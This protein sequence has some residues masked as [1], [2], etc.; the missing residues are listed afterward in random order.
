M[1]GLS[2]VLVLVSLT[3]AALGLVVVRGI[4]LTTL[5]LLA[6]GASIALQAI[7]LLAW[8]AIIVIALAGWLA[9][10]RPTSGWLLAA[11]AGATAVI[12]QAL[13]QTVA[14]AGLELDDRH[15][16]WV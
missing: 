2:V 15:P 4:P 3:T 1:R 12:G 7:V 6:V 14:A 9:A 10:E 8:S 5:N 16:A 13:F 11:G